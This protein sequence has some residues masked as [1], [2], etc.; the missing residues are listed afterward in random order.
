MAI[1]IV[2]GAGYIGSHNVR[3]LWDAGRDVIVVDNLSTGHAQ[4][5]RDGVKLH[6]VDIRDEKSLDAVFGK[7]KIDAVLHFAALSLVGQSMIQPLDY[8]D[9]NVTG[10]IKLL[11]VMQK[12]GVDK[13]V[14]SS[15]AAVY[16]DAETIPI[17]ET[18]T[19]NPTNPY[20]ESKLAMERIMRWASEAYGMRYAVLRYFNVA[21][22]W[23]GGIIGED[24]RPESHL[25]PIILQVALGKRPEIK[26]FGDDYPTK[27]GTC[28]RDY[29]HVMDLVDA[30][31][32]ALEH[33]ENGGDSFICNL[34]NGMGFTVQEM[35]NAAREVT[36]HPIPAVSAARRSGDPA[37]LVASS[38]EAQRILGW[39]PQNDIRQ[40]I[41]SAWTWHKKHPNGYLD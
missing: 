27:D 12:H 17:P 14:F 26:I 32:L 2:G 40:I 19:L 37:K 13:I 9:N 15:T 29:L 21:G 5:L 8:M 24:H 7:E 36:G 25:V 23:E 4:S 31:L 30:H 35:I 11:T 34:G 6:M 10:M 39:H 3:A 1:L 33:L 28:V 38:Q 20:G 18:A 41:E 16:G 22:A